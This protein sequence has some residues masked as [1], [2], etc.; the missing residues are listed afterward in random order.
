MHSIPEVAD[1]VDRASKANVQ[2]AA[3]LK[4]AGIA[5]TTAWRWRRGEF[6]PRYAT[7]AKLRDAL[8]AEIAG[9]DSDKE[10]HPT[11]VPQPHSPK[12]RADA[13]QGVE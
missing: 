12:R 1:M 7:L 3:V 10:S 13:R 8:A 2:W 4:R 6:H 11:R 9:G 5:S